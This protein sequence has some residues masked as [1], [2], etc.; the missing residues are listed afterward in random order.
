MHKILIIDDDDGVRNSLFYHFEDCGYSVSLAISG[1]EAVE[2]LE[3][4]SFDII[5]VDLRLP[6]LR[7]DDFIK[8]VYN[9]TNNTKFIMFTGSEEYTLCHELKAL[10]RVC[11]VV[12][13]KPL[14]NLNLL[15]QEI[16]SL[17][18]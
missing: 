9:K 4:N 15:N 14:V 11:N 7:G 5:I 12:Y 2:L 8:K 1:E 10:P 16:E 18:K 13:Y 6:R 17:L 3:N